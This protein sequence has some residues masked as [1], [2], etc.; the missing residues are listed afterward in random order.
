MSQPVNTRGGSSI[1]ESLASWGD[2]AGLLRGGDQ[3]AIVPVVIPRDTRG[4]RWTV[5]VWFGLFALTSALMMTINSLTAGTT[6]TEFAYTALSIPTLIVGLLSIIAAGLW[7]WRGSIV[8]IEEGTHGILTKYGAIVKPIG[9]GRHYLW[10]PWSRVDFV[11]DTRTE[12]P[13]T[14]PVLACPTRENVPLKSI[15]FFLKFQIMDPIRFVTIIGA[16]NFDL[17]L[18]SAVQDAIRQRSRQVNTES[19]YDLRG[20]NVEDMRRLLNNMLEKYGVRITGCNI[21]DVQLPNQYQQHLATRERVAKELVA[22]EQ[23]WELTRK[24]RIDTLL[25]DIERSK[26][27]RDAKIVEVN[28]SLNKARKDVA[29]MLEEQETEAQRVRYEI[30]TRGRADLVAAENEAKAQQR[31][32]TAYRDNRAVLE[33]EL[34]RRRLDVGATLAEHAPRP[35]VV[36]TEAGAGDTSALST[37]LTAQLLPQMMNGVG[38]S[39]P[40]LASGANAQEAMDSVRGSVAAAAGRQQELAEEYQRQQDSAMR[41]QFERGE[42]YGQSGRR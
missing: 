24:R 12:I 37:L 35:I 26:K 16:S 32:A 6:V 36:Q 11:V 18:S 34:A 30:E 7:W 28:A 1:K 21:P 31:L 20:S 29:Q 41:Q 15:E 42:G 3:G 14:A 5:L 22:Y 13:Y 10:H 38:S 39:R 23:E 17:V 4:L 9:P 27:T 8:E 25:M 40:S 33:Y 2:L 19:A